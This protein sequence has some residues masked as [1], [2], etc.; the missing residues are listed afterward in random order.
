MTLKVVVKDINMFFLNLKLKKGTNTQMPT[1][2]L[3]LSFFHF[4]HF[5]QFCTN[6]MQIGFTINN[7]QIDTA[8]N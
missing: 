6:F 1:N 5:A 2:N 4:L 3:I 8:N 7:L